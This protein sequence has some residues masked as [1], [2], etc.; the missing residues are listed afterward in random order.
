MQPLDRVRASPLFA[1]QI[2][3]STDISKMALLL[4]F[5]R[6]N[7]EGATHEDLLM[8][9]EHPTRTTA[10]ECF[11]CLDGCFAQNGLDWKNC[12]GICT[13]GAASMTSKHSGVV[14]NILDRAPE[15]TWVHCFLHCE[16]LTA[17]EMSVSLNEVMDILFSDYFPQSPKSWEC[18]DSRSFFGRPK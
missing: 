11:C 7:W 4:A 9:N 17:K 1:I 18:V 2:N 14:R 13:D 8:C 16:S 15:A 12:I 5:V 3:K 6:Y 10:D